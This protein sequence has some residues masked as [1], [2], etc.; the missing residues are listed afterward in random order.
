M[1]YVTP[2][3]DLT[4]VNRTVSIPALD[5]ANNFFP[6]DAVS[7]SSATNKGNASKGRSTASKADNVSVIKRN[8]EL[9]LT[10]TY[11]AENV[12]KVST[13]PYIKPV[14]PS[15]TKKGSKIQI[16]L[17]ELDR[18]TVGDSTYDEPLVLILQVFRTDG[19]PI[20]TGQLLN[21]KLMDLYS[22][23]VSLLTDEDP[24]D[25]VQLDRLAHGGTMPVGIR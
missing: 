4:R 6:V 7:N 14:Y 15:A 21:G 24:L 18:N 3:D 17:E 19:N 12:A 25:V 13:N 9:P 2:F 11:T 22:T 10:V 8:S 1:S 5:I 23:A 16:K 20:N